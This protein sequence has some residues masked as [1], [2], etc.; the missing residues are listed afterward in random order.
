MDADRDGGFDE[1]GLEVDEE[2]NPV[3]SEDHTADLT[4]DTDRGQTMTPTGAL[5]RILV[6]GAAGGSGGA[7]DEN[8]DSIMIAVHPTTGTTVGSRG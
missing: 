7:G 1:V 4:K 6:Q 8:K 2:G 5:P 3:W